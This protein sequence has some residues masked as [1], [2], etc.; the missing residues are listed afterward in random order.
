[1]IQLWIGIALLTCL[2]LA[3]VFLPFIRAK[4]DALAVTDVDR[5]EENIAIFKERLSELEAERGAGN[6][7][8]TEFEELKL[9]LERNLLEDATEA[10]QQLQ[11]V[12]VGSKQLLTVV[13]IA[14]ILPVLAFGLYFNYGNAPA[15][16]ASLE[17][18]KTL[19]ADGQQPTVD[20]AIS[21]L[22]AE[23]E[24]HPENAEGW[25]ILATTYMNLGEF[26]KGANSFEKV[27]ALLPTD[28]PQ[29][30]GMMGQYAQAL[31]FSKSG[32]MDEEVRQQIQRTLDIEPLEVTALGLLG[33]DAFEQGM[34]EDAIAFWQKALMNAEPQAAESLKT[35]I[36]R[37]MQELAQAG[38]PVPEVPELAES[39]VSLALKIS[40]SE[41]L[42]DKVS[43]DQA[44]FV[45]A[46]PIGSRMPVAAVKLSVADLPAEVTLDDSMAMMPQAKL[47]LHP[48]VEIGARVSISGQPQAST[49]DLES[50]NVPVAVE[51]VTGE[52][53]LVIDRIVQ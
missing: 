15:L 30:V 10:E 53:S 16:R 50:A 19:F 26:V 2:A 27:L 8:D 4:R 40:L 22:E 29:Y 51:E 18:P 47:S 32:K 36:R 11:S 5:N 45:Y 23:L 48:N 21:M 17:S 7:L 3:F 12:A 41:A 33:I 25:Y 14:L 42:L 43:P 20:E 35:G 28:A 24:K 31:Y 49:G 46:R 39:D 6:L 9:E 52:I 37:A 34:H 38:K 13:L 44:V 1:M